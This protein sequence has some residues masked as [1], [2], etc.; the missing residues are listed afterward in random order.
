MSPEVE[1]AI[2]AGGV[3]VLTVIV[4]LYGTY[5]TSQD[6][7]NGLNEQLAEQREALDRTLKEQREALDKTLAEQ[8]EQAPAD[9]V[10]TAL[11]HYGSGSPCRP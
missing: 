10:I 11:L 1:A 2:I 7:K 9:A 3:G 5:K 6:T 4:A 8:N